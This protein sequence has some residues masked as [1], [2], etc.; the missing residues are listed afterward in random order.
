MYAL[1]LT[2]TNANSK[3]DLVLYPGCTVAS[4]ILGMVV[5]TGLYSAVLAMSTVQCDL[6]QIT[7]LSKVTA[8]GNT[9]QRTFVQ[10]MKTTS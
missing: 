9:V 7:Q 3:V 2:I 1:W 8:C 10:V 6:P 5:L 4:Q